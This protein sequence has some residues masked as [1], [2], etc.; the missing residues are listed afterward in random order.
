MPSSLRAPRSPRCS[1]LARLLGV[2][3]FDDPDLLEAFPGLAVAAPESE[4]QPKKGPALA[5]GEEGEGGGEVGQEEE[6]ELKAASQAEAECA[7][8]ERAAHYALMMNADLQVWKPFPYAFIC[9]FCFV[10]R[11]VLCTQE[12]ANLQVWKPFPSVFILRCLLF[13]DDEPLCL[14]FGVSRPHDERRLEGVE[15][16]PSCLCLNVF[17]ALVM[18]ANLQAWKHFPHVCTLL[19]FTRYFEEC[20]AAGF[21]TLSVCLRN[22]PRLV[23]NN[24]PPLLCFVFRVCAD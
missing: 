7:L 1:P 10:F 16:V 23:R 15:T 5:Q 3:G 17:P 9:L 11:C 21:E 19:C 14:C 18:N 13:P 6:E 12:A 22:V 24:L 2:K 4:S 8:L 20:R